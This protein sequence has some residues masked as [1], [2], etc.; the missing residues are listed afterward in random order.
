MGF[1]AIV[2]FDKA[3]SQSDRPSVKGSISFHLSSKKG[4]HIYIRGEAAGAGCVW[5][6]GAGAR[7]GAAPK[8]I[9]SRSRRTYAA[10]NPAS[11]R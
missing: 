1:V 8:K 4:G 3:D 11:R 9:G 5:P 2:N 6:F 10:P 7:A